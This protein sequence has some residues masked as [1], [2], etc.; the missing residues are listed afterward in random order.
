MTYLRSDTPIH[1]RPPVNQ[2]QLQNR[3]SMPEDNTSLPT[4]GAGTHEVHTTNTV[5]LPKEPLP[6]TDPPV[7]PVQSPVKT[8]PS[9]PYMIAP[10]ATH[11][12]IP[13]SSHYYQPTLPSQHFEDPP[14]RLTAVFGYRTD[15]PENIV[16]LSQI[17]SSAHGQT[18]GMSI[19][20]ALTSRLHR[21]DPICLPSASYQ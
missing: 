8:A 2:S 4:A 7:L 21:N 18:I 19:L 12:T 10:P 20:H 6:Q 17:F 15:T 16:P 5:L 1:V 14:P 11:F 3:E 9:Q 13:T